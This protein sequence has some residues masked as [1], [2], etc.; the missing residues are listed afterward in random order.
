MQLF[1]FLNSQQGCRSQGLIRSDGSG[2]ATFNV[3]Y[4]C[5]T[6]RLWADEVVDAEVIDTTR[7]GFRCNVGPY[8]I[9]VSEKVGSCLSTLCVKR[10]VIAAYIV[11]Q[12]DL[13]VQPG[14]ML[15]M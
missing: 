2:L 11:A 6:L 14:V 13:C 15:S 7:Y 8:K 5:V 9:F 3:A 4:K 10:A 1:G 12:N